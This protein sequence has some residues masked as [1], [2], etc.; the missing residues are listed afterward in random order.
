MQTRQELIL[1]FVKAIAST[2]RTAQVA[3]D[4]M[5]AEQRNY[6]RDV[7]LLA[8]IFADKYIENC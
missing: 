3:T 4:C 6:V 1:E 2:E 8:A 5:S 7:Y